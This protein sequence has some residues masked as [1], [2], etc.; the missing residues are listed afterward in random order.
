MKSKIYGIWFVFALVLTAFVL[1]IAP[2]P[3]V[4]AGG[5][6]LANGPA[7]F[8][9]KAIEAGLKGIAEKFGES[10]KAVAEQMAEFKD[11]LLAVE[12]DRARK[13]GGQPAADG[14]GEIIDLIMKSENLAAFGRKSIPTASIQIP[15]RMF[16]AAIMNPTVT[17]TGNI[18]ILAPADRPRGIV[19]P[20]MRRFVL[21]DILPSV[22]VASGTVEFA[23][24]SAYTNNAQI[25]GVGSSPAET[26][27][28][29]KGESGITFTLGTVT[30]PTIAHWIPASRQVLSD[31]P[32]L[33]RYIDTRLLYG[34]K[35]E[36]EDEFLNGDGSSGH[37]NG[38]VSQATAFAHGVTNQTAI[39]TLGKAMLQLMASEYM[40]TGIILNPADWT[41]ILQIKDQDD[42]YIM[43]SP[44]SMA[45]PRLWGLPVATTNAMT[46]GKF[47]VLDG[48]R[49][50]Y[51][52]DREDAEIRISESHENFF[53][54]NLVAILAEERSTVVVEQAGAMIYGNVSH[55]G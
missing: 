42:N 53:V 50:G 47:L 29:I 20:P 55:A 21:R 23:K 38:L 52:A 28:Q 2:D 34:L 37:V 35:L 14:S 48:T 11:R 41:G 51:I 18:N 8:D 25:Q 44:A 24:E 26:E 36:E 9:L 6:L 1:Y 45:E 22:P 13:P 43:G 15:H 7:G 32:A 39:D 4:A 17:T 40:P 46:A 30:V 5:L 12:Q 27:G 10:Q 33:Q 54:R 49:V 19:M 16:K 3:A 31:A